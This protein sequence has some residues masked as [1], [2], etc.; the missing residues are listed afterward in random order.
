MSGMRKKLFESRV[1]I[2]SL[3]LGKNKGGK[4]DED[5]PKYKR[6]L[7]AE[8]WVFQR[9]FRIHQSMIAMMTNL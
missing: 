5:T 9:R 2:L 8:F 3:D 4:T 6:L 7:S 1:R